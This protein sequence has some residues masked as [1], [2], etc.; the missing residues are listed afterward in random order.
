MADQF[1]WS[2]NVGTKVEQ[3]FWLH[4]GC[5]DRVLEGFVN[6]DF[7][8]T[9]RRVLDWDFL[10]P[11]PLQE[12]QE[13]CEGAFSE[14]VLE[15][16]FLA[17]QAYILSSLNCILRPN[18]VSRVLMPSYQRLVERVRERDARPGG[19]LHDTFGVTTETD[20]INMGLRFSGHRWLHDRTSFARLATSCGFEAAATSCAKSSVPALSNLNLRS[21]TDSASF[22]T[23]LHKRRRM[24]RITVVPTE[25]HQASLVETLDDHIGLYRAECDT[26]LV[27]YRLPQPSRTSELACI[28]IR[29]A[30]LSSFRD[31]FYKHVTLAAPG[32]SGTWRL[33]ETVKSKSGVNLMTRDQIGLATHGMTSVEELRFVPA[34]AGE[35]FT[36][37]N[38]E[39]FIL[40]HQNPGRNAIGPASMNLD[41]AA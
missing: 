34:K 29:S 39:L 1:L 32:T 3:P 14:D 33:D 36:L 20:A 13:Q 21:E 12:W 7:R 4:W 15:H 31:H 24:S 10:D 41:Q 8:P 19:F 35:Y 27:V 30:N 22:A 26:C 40:S 6:A 38:A 28:N 23:D 11:W 16:F 2:T 37:G 5:G 17:E 18:A 25:V 9:D